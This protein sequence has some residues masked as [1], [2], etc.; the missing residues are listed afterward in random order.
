[1]KSYG[2]ICAIAIYT[3]ILHTYNYIL[4]VYT[5]TYVDIAFSYTIANSNA[6]VHEIWKLGT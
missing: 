3:C 6:T 2:I 4:A 1:M 5:C